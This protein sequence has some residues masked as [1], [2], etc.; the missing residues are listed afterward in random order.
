MS[1]IRKMTEGAFGSLK[2]LCGDI[3]PDR[4]LSSVIKDILDGEMASVIDKLDNKD[5]VSVKEFLSLV[6]NYFDTLDFCHDNIDDSRLQTSR[7][8]ISKFFTYIDS[9]DLSSEYNGVL[10]YD[11]FERLSCYSFEGSKGIYDL[12]MI[13]EVRNSKMMKNYLKDN[14]LTSVSNFVKEYYQFYEGLT[15]EEQDKMDYIFYSSSET[16]EFFMQYPEEIKVYFNKN[17]LDNF[18]KESLSLLFRSSTYVAYSD[19]FK[20]DSKFLKVISVMNKY[21]LETTDHNSYFLDKVIQI[22]DRHRPLKSAY[23]KL[24]IEY[25]DN[26]LDD[27]LEKGLQNDE[28]F[29]ELLSFSLSE[30]PLEFINDKCIFDLEDFFK[31][32]RDYLTTLYGRAYGTQHILNIK[33]GLFDLEK[34]LITYSDDFALRRLKKAFFHR[35]YGITIEDAGHIKS[36]YGEFLG[37]CSD[38]FLEEDKATLDILKTICD[39]YDLSVE[40]ESDKDK[41]RELQKDFYLYIK[42]KGL[43]NVNKNAS[44]MMIKSLIDKMYMRTYN[45]VLY[46]VDMSKVLYYQRKVPVIDAGVDFNMIVTSINGVGDFFRKNENSKNRYN[47]S[48]DAS[49]QGICAS[50]INNENLGVIAL[51]GPLLA[52]NNL[53]D[54]SLCAMGVGDIYSDTS[55]IDLGAANSKLREGNYFLTPHEYADNTRFGYNEMVIDRFLFKDE[56][57]IIKVQP[58]YVVCYKV[59]ENYKNTRMYKRSIRFA[60]EF[61]I[62]LVLVDIKKVKEHERDEILLMEKELFSSDKVNKELM[63][64]I[65]TRYMNNYSGSLTIARTRGLRGNNWNYKRDFSIVGMDRFIKKVHHKLESFENDIANVYEWYD[66]LKECY[67]VEKKRNEYAHEVSSYANS[68]EPGEFVLDDK[69]EFMDRINSFTG[70]IVDRYYLRNNLVDGEKISYNPRLEPIAEM[71]VIINLSNYLFNHAYVKSE[72]SMGER[73]YLTK[74]A[75]DLS[76]EEKCAYGLAISHLLGNFSDNYF[77]NLDSCDFNEF[78]F[79]NF[80]ESSSLA[81]NMIKND[82]YSSFVYKTPVLIEVAK[83]INDMHD[84]EFRTIFTP[85]IE[86]VANDRN[87]SEERVYR[88]ILRRKESFLEEVSKLPVLNN[89]KLNNN[90][91][92]KK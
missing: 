31:A 84:D 32:R 92:K 83:K 58:S 3:S 10:L 51:N 50:F 52:Y 36:R 71:D 6:S 12:L 22:F 29:Q 23:T 7:D 15:E 68:L 16:L 60:E 33:Y 57:N 61:G 9:L 59:D 54:T 27:A 79:R 62:P 45:K 11:F 78:G 1:L 53:S 56:D 74:A 48:A 91:V 69:I 66:A 86:G 2:K 40:N 75:S 67:M 88:K 43:Y 85:I 77:S 35:V 20:T 26:Y 65:L 73:I 30:D 25:C 76:E 14:E 87:V 41:I 47:G 4:N 46:D 55:V 34:D 24:F 49:N 28:L 18:N 42:E 19:F 37:T 21:V 82:V 70:R 64:E 89:V 39:V 17:I 81:D 8:D 44:F 80:M 38:K 13:D 72:D 5:D 63:L 90:N